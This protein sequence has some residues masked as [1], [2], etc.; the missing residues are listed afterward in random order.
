[1]RLPAEWEKQGAVQLT[2]PDDTTPWYE[3]EKVQECLVIVNVGK[4]KLK[5][6]KSISEL[7]DKIGVTW[8]AV[9]KFLQYMKDHPTAQ[10]S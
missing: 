7:D 8:N 9:S 5:P 1:M 6:I 3:L 10:V 2:W 4:E